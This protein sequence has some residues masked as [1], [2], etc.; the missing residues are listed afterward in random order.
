[1]GNSIEVIA[2]LNST[3]WTR[4]EN[5]HP[6]YELFGNSMMSQGVPFTRYAVKGFLAMLLYQEA[7]GMY[8]I[9]GATASTEAALIAGKL[10]DVTNSSTDLCCTKA[11]ESDGNW[12]SLHDCHS[13]STSESSCF[14]ANTHKGGQ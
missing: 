1:M 6:L 9:N 14:G 5:S 8:G 3:L 11:R 10:G 2:A 12:S 4:V 13:S 7:G